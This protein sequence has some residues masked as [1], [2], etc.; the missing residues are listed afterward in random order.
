MTRI[1]PH[2][3]FVLSSALSQSRTLKSP[4]RSAMSGVSS[5]MRSLKQRS[6]TNTS[7]LSSHL[8]LTGCMMFLER[9]VEPDG[10]IRTGE[11]FRGALTKRELSTT[12]PRRQCF[13]RQHELLLDR[14]YFPQLGAGPWRGRSGRVPLLGS[15]AHRTPAATVECAKRWCERVAVRAEKRE[16]RCRVVPPVTVDVLH[17]ERDFSR[18]WM[19]LAPTTARTPLS[20][21]LDQVATQEAAIDEGWICAGFEQRRVDLKSIVEGATRRTE[22]CTRYRDATSALILAQCPELFRIF[23]FKASQILMPPVCHFMR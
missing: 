5:G 12:Q 4:I 19:S 21:L 3:P 20:E 14:G 9:R 1:G 17:L 10:R 8:G 15:Q 22:D 18:Y 2:S 6:Q 11:L 16:V 13:H 23:T 7:P